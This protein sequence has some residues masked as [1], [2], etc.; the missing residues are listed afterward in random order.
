MW[1]WRKIVRINLFHLILKPSASLLLQNIVM[2]TEV[3]NSCTK[4]VGNHILPTN[5]AEE[6]GEQKVH[7]PVAICSQVTVL[8]THL[9]AYPAWGLNQL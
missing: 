2:S 8:V 1:K 4:G 9:Y 5:A 3:E 7:S 6:R